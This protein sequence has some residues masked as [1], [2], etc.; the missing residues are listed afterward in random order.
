MAQQHRLS[1]QT[2]NSDRHSID[3][4]EDQ[5]FTYG[6]ED[7]HVQLLPKDESY[8]DERERTR[9]KRRRRRNLWAKLIKSSC[10]VLAAGL[11]VTFLQLVISPI[12]PRC[13]NVQV[14]RE[15]R[16]LNET[17]KQQY[18]GSVN[19][20]HS[21]SSVLKNN[22]NATYYDDFSWVHHKH[23]LHSKFLDERVTI[24]SIL[25]IE[26][27]PPNCRFFVMA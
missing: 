3:I 14:R 9:T 7:A 20:L 5:N 4:V 24:K 2:S 19:C 11:G 8:P 27:S 26:P 13:G 17:E 22:D 10:V 21:T 25:T 12:S 18:I 23:A 16:Q 15:W 6:D 1:P